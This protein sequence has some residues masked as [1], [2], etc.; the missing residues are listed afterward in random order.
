MAKRAKKTKK[1]LGWLWLL[2]FMIVYAGAALYAINYGLQIFWNYIASYET[3]RPNKPIEAYMEELTREHIVDLAD[4]VLEQVDT[5]LQSEAECRS[6]MLESISGNISYAR[7]LKECTDTKTVYMI[8]CGGK[9]IGKVTTEAGEPDEFGF[10]VW[11]V[12][13]ESYDLSY[14]VGGTVTVTAPHDHPVLVNGVALDESYIVETGIQ[15][16]LLKD[17]YEDFDLPY[18]VT[19]TAGPILGE[20]EAVITSP[21][22]QVVT[23][24]ENTDWNTFIETCTEDQITDVKAFV[25]EYLDSY[26]AFTSSKDD[27]YAKYKALIKYMDDNG[28]LP[29]RMKRALDG[30]RFNRIRYAKVISY[31]IHHLVDT[32]DGHYL[33]WLTY[34]TEMNKGEGNYIEA[35]NLQLTLIEKNGKLL[36]HAMTSY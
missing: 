36:T 4:G 6:V 29:D 32:G 16:E 28:S 7:N 17:Y 8:L 14:L 2:L 22:G 1:R 31:T 27:A 19:Y 5:N 26:V 24:D 13:Q 18:I 20:P 12:T 33:V 10:S 23:I 30:L 3:S 15:Y 9:T 34:E 21:A 11:S 35:N 25:E